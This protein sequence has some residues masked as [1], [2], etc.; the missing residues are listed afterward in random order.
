[1]TRHATDA[2]TCRAIRDAVAEAMPAQTEFLADLTRVPSVRGQEGPA[3]DLV[4]G[5][6]GAHGMAVDDWTVPVDEL[7]GQ[8]GFCRAAGEVPSVRSVVGTHRPAQARGRSLILQ[9]HLDVVPPGPEGMWTTPPFEPVLRDGW[10]HGRGAGDMKAGVSANLFALAALARAGVAPAAQVHLQAVVEEEST[11]LGALATL[12]RGYRAD[13][14][15]IPEPTA[16]GLVRAQVGVLW[17]RLEVAGRPVHAAEAGQGANA[18]DA[19]WHVIGALREMEARWN[20]AAAADPLYG[21]V[22]HPLNF[23]PGRISGGDWASSVPAWCHADCRMGL[24]P[25]ADVDEAKAEIEATVAEAA[26]GHPFLS[27]HPP[28]VVWNGFE[29]EGYVLDHAGPAEAALAGAYRQVFGEDGPEDRIWTAL[30]DT[31]FYGLYHGIPGVC[32]GP[33]AEGIHGFDE[34]VDLGSL[35]QCTETIALFVAAWCG[36]EPA[37]DA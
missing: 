19:A 7:S 30:T 13:C 28:R 2:A 35:Q 26:R 36:L 1:M 11:G 23:N 10:M 15:L 31:R 34:R 14:A 18:I 29:A 9:G 25:G 8:P 12:A 16:H 6:L 21:G 4:A 20:A 17:F 22:A 37:G 5:A 3:L 32:F 27:A 24:L 33:R